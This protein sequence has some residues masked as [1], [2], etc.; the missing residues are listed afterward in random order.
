MKANENPYKYFKKLGVVK[1]K[2]K[3]SKTFKEEELIAHTLSVAPE[4]Y[5]N[6]LTHTLTTCGYAI[7]LDDIKK[8]LK[9]NYRLR[10][11]DANEDEEDT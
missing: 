9:T 3:K 7:T 6:T 8:A 11:K 2:W 10:H 1:S 5:L 4:V